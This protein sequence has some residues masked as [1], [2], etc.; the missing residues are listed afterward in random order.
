MRQIGTT[1]AWVHTPKGAEPHGRRRRISAACLLPAAH[2]GGPTVRGL[3][4]E[5]GERKN[6][7]R[8]VAA[9]TQS[10]TESAATRKQPLGGF[11][12]Q[13]RRNA[14]CG[15]RNSSTSRCSHTLKWRPRTWEAERKRCLHRGRSERRSEIL[16]ADFH[17]TPW[18]N[19]EEG[20]LNQYGSTIFGQC[21][22]SSG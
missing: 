16:K 7:L 3:V 10:P 9:N 20:E 13:I 19:S 5:D 14:R 11:A 4:R 6:P 1:I 21:L 2:L 8:R 18:N 15:P 17:K 12:P 22:R